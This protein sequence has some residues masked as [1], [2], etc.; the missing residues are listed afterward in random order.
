MR[1]K[2][3]DLDALLKQRRSLDEGDREALMRA[4][5]YAWSW[6]NRPDGPP[7]PDGLFANC[8]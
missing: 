5:G 6:I 4:L 7:H 3:F 1:D 8:L 2:G